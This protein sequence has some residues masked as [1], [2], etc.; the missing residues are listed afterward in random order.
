MRP[1]KYVFVGAILFIVLLASSCRDKSTEVN[2]SPQATLE[3]SS[4]QSKFTNPYALAGN[5]HNEGL[6]FM[7]QY[8]KD[9]KDQMH[10]RED[11]LT[12]AQNALKAYFRKTNIQIDDHAISKSFDDAGKKVAQGSTLA[13]VWNIEGFS[14]EQVVFITRLKQIY[15]AGL[16]PGEIRDALTKLNYDAISALG[17]EKSTPILVTSAVFQSS[18]EYW[19]AQGSEWKTLMTH[20][21]GLKK[22]AEA[23]GDPDWLTIGGA[24]AAGALA[25]AIPCVVSTVAYA[26]CVGGAATGASLV[27]ATIWLLQSW[28]FIAM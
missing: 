12:H 11:M 27:A 24:D 28:G 6:D 4:L 9:H 21:K 25:A 8:L 5:M 16:K 13:P 17:P 18:T 7:L 10:N 1:P 22:G 20:A 3:N 26:V 23:I 15:G 2:S 14:Q 19:S